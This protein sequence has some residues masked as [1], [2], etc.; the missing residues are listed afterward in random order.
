MNEAA[1][2][3]DHFAK[4]YSRRRQVGEYVDGRWE[5]SATADD[6]IQAAIFSVKPDDVKSLPEGERLTVSFTM[7]TRAETKAVSEE[8][9]TAGDLIMVG[10]QWHRV[11]HIADRAE[12][13]YF[14]A[15]L[16]R[17]VERNRS[18]SRTAPVVEG[19]DWH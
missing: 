15:L 18:V 17:N 10:S 1:I 5:V 12:G 8:N 2:A 16:E 19:G 3:I 13:G 9:Q 7:W 4:L 11:K 14:K 6:T